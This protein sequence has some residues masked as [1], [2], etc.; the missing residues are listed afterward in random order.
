MKCK[1][2]SEM[3]RWAVPTASQQ[4]QE[5]PLMTCK[6]MSG[7]GF[8]QT[9]LTKPDFRSNITYNL[10]LWT[11]VLY[12]HPI[13]N[14]LLTPNQSSQWETTYTSTL[15]W[16]HN[17]TEKLP[18]PGGDVTVI[19]VCVSDVGIVR[20]SPPQS[21]GKTWTCTWK[22]ERELRYLAVLLSFLIL[23]YKSH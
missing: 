23:W 20:K 13:C 1:Q 4:G 8:P 17:E 9:G 19:L 18:S 5:W 12:Y 3:G 2:M 16:G 10:T 6:Q 14:H 21:I 7:V 22:P 11:C 15:S